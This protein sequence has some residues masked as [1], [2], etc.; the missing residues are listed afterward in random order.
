MKILKEKIIVNYELFQ[1]L[2]FEDNQTII[3]CR[4][5][6]LHQQHHRLLLPLADHRQSPL[7]EEQRHNPK[8]A[9]HRQPQRLRHPDHLQPSPLIQ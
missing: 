1:I 3:S 5:R 8:Q 4:A 7:L 9:E 2:N 6:P